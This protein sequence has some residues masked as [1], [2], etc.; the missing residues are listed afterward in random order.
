VDK[1]SRRQTAAIS[2]KRE[3]IELNLQ[4]DHRQREDHEA[5]SRIL[6]RIAAEAGNVE[7]TPPTAR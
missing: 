3:D 1:G 7:K 4:E 5:E 6:C 2:E